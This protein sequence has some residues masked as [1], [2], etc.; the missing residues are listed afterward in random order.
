MVS[1]D[2]TFNAHQLLLQVCDLTT[3]QCVP[4]GTPFHKSALGITATVNF[5]VNWHFDYTR[6]ST[7]TLTSLPTGLSNSSGIILGTKYGMF[8]SN[9]KFN[10]APTTDLRI[11][12]T[13]GKYW[14]PEKWSWSEKGNLSTWWCNCLIVQCS[15]TSKF[16]V[17]GLSITK[18]RLYAIGTALC[19]TSSSKHP[20]WA[21]STTIFGFNLT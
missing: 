18:L 10:L 15:I 20:N 6:L 12:G 1:L 8:Q 7:W 9:I 21:C 13:K 16:K 17:L 5:C 4:M 11:F 3:D 14:I 19:T 2:D